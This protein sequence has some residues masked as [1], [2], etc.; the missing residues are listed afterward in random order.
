MSRKHR[1]WYPGAS[2]HVTSR[3]NRKAALFYE[4][5]DRLQYLSILEE[6]RERYPF[7]LFSYCLMNNHLHLQIKTIQDHPQHFMKM[8]N[9]RYAKFFNKKYELVGHVFQGRY[10]SKLIQS[11]QYQLQ[12]SK[13]VHLNPVE[14]GMILSPQDYRWSSC[15]AYVSDQHNR[16]VTTEEILSH[17]EQPQKEKYYQYLLK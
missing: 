12:V 1:I 16:H 8:I 4:D 17:F 7:Q 3:G 6:A 11:I 14:A 2:F 15:A 5:A 9:T 13:Y 10:G